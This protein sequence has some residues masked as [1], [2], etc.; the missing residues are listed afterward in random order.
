MRPLQLTI[1]GFGPYAGTQ[2][3]DFEK[4]GQ[5]GLY[6]ITGD[7]GA[8]KTTIFD[9]ITFALFGEASGD[10]REPAMLRSKY[11]KAADPTFVELAFLYDGKAYTVRRN[12]EYERAKARGIGTT[13]EAANAELTYPDGRVVTKQREVDKAIR[14]IIGL[15]REQFSQIA[16]ISQGDFR[17]LLQAGTAERQKIFR[18]IFGTGLYVTLQNQLKEKTSAVREQREQAGRSIRQY[19]DG[20]MCHEDSL[21]APEVKK[22][23][24]GELP[25]ADVMELFDHLLQEDQ[26]AQDAL[27]EQMAALEGK[28]EQVNAQLTQADT[29]AQTKKTLADQEVAQ[30]QQKQQLEQAVAALAAAQETAPEQE[31]LGRSITELELLLP[32]YDELESTAAALSKKNHALSNARTTEADALQTQS[33][34]TQEIAVLKAEQQTLLS[35]EA[36]KER[37]SALRSQLDDRCSQFRTL[38][39]RM[40]TLAS[41]QALLL[42][43]QQAYLSAEAESTRL[44]QV[45]DAANKAF[46]HEQAGLLAAALPVGAPCPVCGSTEHPQLATLSDNAPTEADVKKAKADYDKAQAATVKASGEASRQNGIVSATDA[47]VRE[48]AEEL[49]PGTA[50][51]SARAAAKEQSEALTGQI[52]TL[53]VQIAKATAGIKRKTALDTLIPRKEQALAAADTALTGAKE[54]IAAAQTAVEALKMQIADMQAKLPFPQKADAITAQQQR[55]SRLSTLKKAQTDAESAHN[56]C[57]EALAGT[58]AAIAQ[59]RQQLE[60][61]AEPDTA[62]LETEKSTLL[63]QRTQITTA[64]KI[65]HTRITT[66]D[67]AQRHIVGKAQE[68]EALD[69]RYTWM[70]ALSETANGTLSG[71]EKL[72]LETYI[73]T[74]YFERILERANIRLRKMSGG[75]YD[76]KRRDSADNKRSQSGLELD[77]V[78]HINATQ[79]SVNT[80]SGGESFLASLALALGLSDEVQ[81]ST[82]IRLDTLFVDE[83]FGSLDSESLSKAYLTL[84]SLTEGNRLVGIISH[85]AELKDRIDRQ[86]V[87]KKEPGGGSRATIIV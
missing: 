29:Y 79:R 74:T 47:A 56:R 20:M 36:E 25:M 14:E 73:Q 45:Y 16:M 22:A 72:M 68:L 35:V 4:L 84:A 30:L 44:G 2:V 57:K 63:D 71:K 42:K 67:S 61:S 11:T 78:D 12:P 38:T 77:I 9:A 50:L 86:I 51:T 48:M 53:D 87:V 8:G 85:V 69:E 59:L 40:D 23:K 15:S 28:L 32:A 75:Q 64:Q 31:A 13:K 80:L 39:E 62:A 41:Q 19:I 43:K 37:L 18:D 3:L 7:T 82:G 46:L 10:S 66:N 27:N 65:L 49:L 6:L 24:N 83:G 58:G 55:R 21:L 60:G 33:T 17:K 26:A 5:N 76:L 70:K 81:M 34:L 54:Q 52:H 1:A